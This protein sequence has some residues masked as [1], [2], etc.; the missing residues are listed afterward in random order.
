[1]AIANDAP[2]RRRQGRSNINSPLL[3]RY[4]VRRKY[5]LPKMLEQIN[6]PVAVRE[7]KMTKFSVGQLVVFLVD[8]PDVIRF[9]R[10]PPPTSPS[11][12]VAKSPG[13]SISA[14]ACWRQLTSDRR[15]SLRRKI[16]ISAPPKV[17]ANAVTLICIAF[18]FS[19]YFGCTYL[20]CVFSM[21]PLKANGASSK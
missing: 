11:S 18:M 1:M 4:A 5:Q 16:P 21:I 7:F 15:A 20:I 3:Q 13:H 19:D 9:D 14:L 8:P 2:N 12:T 17:H 6:F 10:E